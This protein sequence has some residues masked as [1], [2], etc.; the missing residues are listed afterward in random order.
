MTVRMEAG[1]SGVWYLCCCAC[2]GQRLG[3]RLCTGAQQKIA[4]Y[5]S[6]MKVLWFG[7]GQDVCPQQMQHRC[8]LL[9]S[10]LARVRRMRQMRPRKLLRSFQQWL[11]RRGH[12][13]QVVGPAK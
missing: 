4:T 11:G 3:Q 9:L 2:R 8:P 1:T 10:Q 12:A 13:A 7:R 6:Q 5:L